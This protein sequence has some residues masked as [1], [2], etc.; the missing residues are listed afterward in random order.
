MQETRQCDQPDRAS[1]TDLNNYIARLDT[2]TSAH[3]DGSLLD[4]VMVLDRPGSV[5]RQ[6]ADR[7]LYFPAAASERLPEENTTLRLIPYYAWANRAPSAM[8]VWIPYRQA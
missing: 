3:F 7:G 8:Q 4:G 5:T 6:T 2:A 1:K